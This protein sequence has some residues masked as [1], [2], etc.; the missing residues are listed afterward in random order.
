MAAKKSGKKQAKRFTKGHLKQLNWLYIIFVI[1]FTALS[2]RIFYIQQT[3]GEE[4]TGKTTQGLDSKVIP[5]R[6]GNITDRNGTLL[7]TSE[8]VYNLIFDCKTINSDESNKEPVLSKLCELYPDLDRGVLEGYLVNEPDSQYKILKKSLRYEEA[9]ELMKAKEEDSKLDGVWFEEEYKRVYPFNTLACDV[10]GFLYDD[11]SSAGLGLEGYYFDELN[12]VNGRKYQYIDDENK[13]TVVKDATDGNNIVSTIDYNIQSIVEKHIKAFDEQYTNSVREGNGAE[14]I[15]V[16]IAD[17]DSGEI[18]AE[19]NFPYFDLN[20]PRDITKTGVVSAESLYVVNDDMSDDEKKA[21]NV[22]K[23]DFLRGIWRN[24]CVSDSYEPGSTQKPFTVAAG[25][26][27]GKINGTEK[28]ICDGSELVGGHTIRCVKRS[29]HGEETIAQAISNSCNDVLMQI[30]SRIGVESFIHYQNIWGFGKKTNIDLPSE[31]NCSSLVYTLDTMH[32]TELATSSFGQGYNVTMTQMMAAFCSLIN[33]GN[34]YQPHMVKKI[35]DKNGSTVKNIDSYLVRKTVSKETSEIVKSY[36]YETVMNGTGKTAHVEGYS[37]GGKTGTAE[38]S[39]RQKK[40]YVVSFIGYAPADNPQVAIY[41]VID[42]PNV[43]DQAHSSFSQQI[44]HDILA[45]VLPYMN[46]FPDMTTDDTQ[47]SG[48]DAAQPQEGDA[49]Q[50]QEG[51]AAQ[52]QEGDNTAQPQDGDNTAQ[53]EGSTEDEG[54]IFD[55][56]MTF[57]LLDNA[58]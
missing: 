42:T 20:S 55:D 1:I 19:A 30:A 11:G 54:S 57:P 16:M 39:D 32:E 10:L 51:D 58:N 2:I 7:A 24:F 9:E 8:K 13:E 26:E 6:R 15:A 41:V 25:L 49:A 29:G 53:P 17:P 43:A 27:T 34:Y 44:A 48:G 47:S 14:E 46:I 12:G 5:F 40:N 4:Y 22:A 3:K 33:G 56:N 50:P 18:L 36:L 21:V 52:P 45:E 28:F 23:L 37:M 38:K 35:T 31:F